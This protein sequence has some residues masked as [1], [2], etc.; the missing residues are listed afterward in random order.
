VLDINGGELRAGGAVMLLCEVLE[1]GNEGVRV[2]VMNS[3]LE[4][5]IGAK[6]DE[7]LGGAVADSEL[8]AFEP[9]QPPFSSFEQ[10]VADQ[11]PTAERQGPEQF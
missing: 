9:D 7:V 8:T 5:L 4:I 10:Q 6:F 11:C 3:D 2:R 1:V